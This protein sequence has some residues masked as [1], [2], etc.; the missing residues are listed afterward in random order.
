MARILVTGGSGFLGSHLVNRLVAEGH[1]VTV[2]T[3]RRDHAKHLIVLP[4]IDVLQ[5]DIHDDATLARLVAGSDAVVNLVGVLHSPSGAPY[6]PA[7]ARAHVELPRR[8]IEACAKAGVRR[9]VHVSAIGAD[10]GAPSEYLRSKAD[11]EAALLAARDRI[12]ATVFRPSVM[13][14]P[15]DRFMNLFASLQRW[16]PVLFLACPEARFQPVYVGDVVECMARA[17]GDPDTARKSA[18]RNYDLCGPQ[19]FSLRQLAAYAGRVSGHRRPIIGLGASLSMLQAA[20][21]EC[22]PLKLMSRDNVRSMQVPSVCDCEFPFGITPAALEA[23]AP[24]YLAQSFPRARYQTF[25][26]QAGR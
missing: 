1:A 5:A 2:P 15:G 23:I 14:G 19:Q 4:S 24:T 13:F 20:A 6:G 7:F 10:S 9:L 26:N 3:R 8:L 21:L 12:D 18:H 17:L 16:T 22:L 25:R 11:G